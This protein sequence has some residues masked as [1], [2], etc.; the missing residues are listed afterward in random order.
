MRPPEKGSEERESLSDRED[1]ALL[2][3][4]NV[5]DDVK[6]EIEE[7]LDRHYDEGLEEEE[8]DEGPPPR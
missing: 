3:N 2:D 5:P 7:R 6:S 4:P 1:R 8:G